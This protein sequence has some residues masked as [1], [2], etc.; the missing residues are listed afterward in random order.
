MLLPAF[1][2]VAA[3]LYLTLPPR[4][5][6]S[7]WGGLACLLGG[8]YLL[9]MRAAAITDMFTSGRQFLFW[10]F[11]AV[12]LTGAVGTITNRNPVFCALWF[13]LSLLGTAALFMFI[14]AQFLALATVVV[15]AGA[16][17]VTFLFV[18][19]L[20][21]PEGQAPY[22][23][24]SWE[25]LVSAT[26]GAAIIGLLTST[27]VRLQA[28]FARAMEDERLAQATLDRA[29]NIATETHVAFLGRELF[30]THLLSVQAAGLLLFVALV[31]AVAIVSHG[32][33][34]ERTESPATGSPLG[35]T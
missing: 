17:L 20:A 32:R 26:S 31:G 34:K 27:L 30:S 23:R 11:A 25:P 24:L 3:G 7:W 16:I 13:G 10:T 1:L 5:G 19:M 6:W 22:D 8:F 4:R 12:T 2:L 33:A 18:L 29:S 15:Y 21:T 9:G 14:G 35:G 28:P